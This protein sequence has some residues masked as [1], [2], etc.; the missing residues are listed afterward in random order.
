MKYFLALAALAV[1]VHAVPNL[2]PVDFADVDNGEEGRNCD[3]GAKQVCARKKNNPNVEA[4]FLCENKVNTARWTIY[5]CDCAPGAPQ[6]CARKK[7]N[8]NVEAIFLCQNEVNTARWT[9]Y[10][11][12][13]AARVGA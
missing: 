3:P 9:I 2:R 4:I 1:P 13:R 7:N 8:P 12:D 6:V 11:C 5:N 10:N